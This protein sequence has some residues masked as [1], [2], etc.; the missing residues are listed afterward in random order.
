M[1]RPADTPAP[2]EKAPLPIPDNRGMGPPGV[3][4]KYEAAPPTMGYPGEPVPTMGYPGEPVPTMG[5]P[6]EALPTM[7]YPGEPLPTMGYPGR[8]DSPQQ[9]A[10]SPAQ[11][12][13]LQSNNK[14]GV[15]ESFDPY[16]AYYGGSANPAR[17]SELQYQNAQPPALAPLPQTRYEP[18]NESR[19]APS[20]YYSNMPEPNNP[21]R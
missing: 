13:G 7:G 2:D 4:F 18:P 16:D 17:D 10:L 11:G 1:A 3:D 20:S 21:R 6:G 19:W 15:R 14:P 9:E 8:P 5:Y 12:G